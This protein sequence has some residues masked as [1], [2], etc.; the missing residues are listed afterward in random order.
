MVAVNKGIIWKDWSGGQSPGY[1]IWNSGWDNILSMKEMYSEA[2]GSVYS[3]QDSIKLIKYKKIRWPGNILWMQKKKNEK[4]IYFFEEPEGKRA[5]G[6]TKSRW[7][8]IIYGSSRNRV[9]CYG[10]DLFRSG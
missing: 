5:R 9:A 4:F 6:R 3:P 10:L 2:L 1:T 8:I 7:R